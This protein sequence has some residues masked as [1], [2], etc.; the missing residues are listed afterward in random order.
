VPHDELTI[1]VDVFEGPLA[2]I[3]VGEVEFDSTEASQAFEPPDWLG[4]EVTGDP[5]YAN[6]S[7]AV[8]G[9]PQGGAS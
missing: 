9:A 7:L 5:R 3:I 6:E 8:R 2:G 4:D 1:E